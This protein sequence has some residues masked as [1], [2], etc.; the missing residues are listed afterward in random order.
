M[1]R[2]GR[3]SRPSGASSQTHR[4]VTQAPDRL[5]P[6]RAGRPVRDPGLLPRRPDRHPGGRA[7]PGGG[8]ERGRHGRHC[9]PE[10]GPGH[11]PS[12]PCVGVKGRLPLRTPGS[13]RP[14]AQARRTAMRSLRSQS[15]P[16]HRPQRQLRPGPAHPWCQSEMAADLLHL[17]RTGRRL[18]LRTWQQGMAAAPRPVR[19]V[20][21][22]RP[23]RGDPGRYR[24]PRANPRPAAPGQR[25]HLAIRPQGPPAPAG[26]SS[27]TTLWTR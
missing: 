20:L 27:P 22:V 11:R 6:G 9:L 1:S 17:L 7:T 25:H 5:N 12:P 23:A 8:W 21:P 13:E 3:E 19:M 10:T 4:L 14:S 16:A 2:P 15:L 18:P 26:P 24:R